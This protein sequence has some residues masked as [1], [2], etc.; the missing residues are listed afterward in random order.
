MNR[1]IFFTFLLM[2][3]R[4][5]AMQYP[6]RSTESV[7]WDWFLDQPG[8]IISTAFNKF[9]VGVPFAFNKSDVTWLDWA[10]LGFTRPSGPQLRWPAV[11]QRA[12][13]AGA[14][15]GEAVARADE[16][17]PYVPSVVG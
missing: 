11:V 7:F 2:A 6:D 5:L 17:F 9:D 13:R 12:T 14:S 1:T 16:V 4:D 15:W 3:V 10:K 8:D